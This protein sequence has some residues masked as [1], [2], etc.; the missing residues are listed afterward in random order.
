MVISGKNIRKRCLIEYFRA[1][2]EEKIA[3]A[4]GMQF[5]NKNF[6]DREGILFGIL[7]VFYY[8]ME[9]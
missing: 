7:V 6:T 3:F 4:A 5:L 1:C 8:E 9:C 2:T